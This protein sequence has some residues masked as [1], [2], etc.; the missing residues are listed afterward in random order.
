MKKKSIV[1]LSAL[2]FSVSAISANRVT[3]SVTAKGLRRTVLP[4]AK[5]NLPYKPPNIPTL[6]IPRYAERYLG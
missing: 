5:S 3:A 2:L 4:K 1:L 6:P